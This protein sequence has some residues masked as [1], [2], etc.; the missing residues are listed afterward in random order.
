MVTNSLASAYKQE[1]LAIMF[2][3]QPQSLASPGLDESPLAV[4]PDGH[5]VVGVGFG[6]K[7]SQGV[8][9]SE[10]A[11]R[12]YV[13]KKL[14]LSELPT[15]EVVPTTVNGVTTDVVEIGDLMTQGRPVACGSSIGHKDIAAGTLGC[16]VRM[17]DSD[18]DMRYILSN[19]H[20]LANANTAMVGDP[21]LEPALED[22]G[23]LDNPIAVLADFEAL[24]LAVKTKNYMDAAIARV[25][26]PPDVL[27]EILGIGTI[28]APAMAAY[29][30]QSVQKQGRTTK[31]TLGTVSDLEA[32]IKVAYSNKGIAYFDNQI[33][34]AGVDGKFS[35]PGDSGSL[36]L[37]VNT[38]QP[39]GL[40]FTGGLEASFASPILSIL[41][42][43][44]IEIL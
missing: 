36:V 28:K 31:R 25:L 4:I 22:G 38:L 35:A 37:D 1:L 30:G 13:R 42:R 7:T 17:K 43:F 5:N 44:N 9:F 21:I 27:A 8:I 18:T 14:P 11:V 40:L 41:N 3:Y 29:E 16:L 20:V 2:G 6:L 15:D 32:S 23:L 26:N 34:I 19:N 39:I 24:K 33:A 12:I 10:K